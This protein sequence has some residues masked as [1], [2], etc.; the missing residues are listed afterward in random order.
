MPGLAPPRRKEATMLRRISLVVLAFSFMSLPA[1][2]ADA[3]DRHSGRVLDIKGQTIVLEEMGPWLGPNTGIVQ[4]TIQFSP[5][6]AVRFVRSTGEWNDTSPGYEVRTIDVKDLKP[7]DFVT[8]STDAAGRMAQ[9]VEVMR[10]DDA[11]LA[12]PK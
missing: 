10:S 11:G 12:S 1:L 5:G 9:A 6:T 8:I 2:A 7:G 4:R 3:S